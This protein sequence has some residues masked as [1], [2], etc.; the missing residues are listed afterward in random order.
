MLDATCWC[1]QNMLTQRTFSNFAELSMITLAITVILAIV[2][3]PTRNF[4]K[5]RQISKYLIT[6]YLTVPSA[7]LMHLPRDSTTLDV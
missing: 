3:D 4:E 2:V 5:L 1:L 7:D 6:Y